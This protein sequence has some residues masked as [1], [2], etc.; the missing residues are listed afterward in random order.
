MNASPVHN[1]MNTPLQLLLLPERTGAAAVRLQVD[2]EG[3]ILAREVVTTDGAPAVAAG[4]DA[5]RQVLAVPGADCL[6]LWLRL[7]ARNPVQA[8]A[9]ARVLVEDHVAAPAGALH[10]AIAAPPTA[11]EGR[12]VVAVE[13][14]RMQGWLDRGAALGMTPDIVVPMPLLLPAPDTIDGADEV[15]VVGSFDDQSLVR[16]AQLAFAGEPELAA[17]IVGERTVRE[18]DA[19]AT[20]A[21][22]AAGALSPPIDLLQYDFARTAPRR[23]GWPAWRRAA[24]LAGVLAVSPLALLAAQVA[25]YELSAHDLQAQV[26]AQART[27]LPQLADD[28][29]PLPAIRERL[30]VLQAGDRFGHT[31]GA[32]LSAVASADGAELDAL[33]YAEGGVQATLVVDAPATLERIRG[34]LAAAGLEMTATGSQGAGGRLRHDITIRPGA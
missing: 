11:D 12:L 24:I 1:A 21:A 9:A 20:E 30:S 14:A 10:L 4:H 3:R 5:A 22:L 27:A 16:G 17:H 6:A 31:V 33:A 28:A 2:T 32:L 15:M 8:L 7:P 25:Q 23:E 13:P 29:D 34:S 26:R 19:A 18:L